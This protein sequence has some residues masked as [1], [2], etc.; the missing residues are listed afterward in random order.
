[1]HL[2]CSVAG[3]AKTIQ[4]RDVP[5]D[6][7]AELRARAAAAGT[8][9]SDYVLGEL[10]RVS[11]HVVVLD[12][13]TLLR[14]SA[15]ADFTGRTGGLLV[16]VLGGPQARAQLGEALA[17][18]GLTCRPRGN[19]VAV[20]PPPEGLAVHDL[21]RDTAVDLGLALVRVQPDQAHLEDVFL[22]GGAR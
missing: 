13:G 21:V 11:D 4:V 10:E 14:S 9:L 2:A 16:E 19:L 22:A 20:D 17:Q 1:M 3:M 18:A 12:G 7:H 5:E 8:S 15:T 6:V